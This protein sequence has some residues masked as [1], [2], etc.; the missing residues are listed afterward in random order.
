MDQWNT[1]IKNTIELFGFNHKPEFRLKSFNETYNSYKKFT[2]N[3][4]YAQLTL[5]LIV[6]IFFESILS[7]D[8]LVIFKD[9]RYLP[10]III[11]H[12]I[13]KEYV[14]YITSDSLYYLQNIFILTVSIYCQLNILD[15]QIQLPWQLIMIRNIEYV[16]FKIIYILLCYWEKN[17]LLQI[18]WIF[19][20]S[21][22]VIYQEIAQYVS[23]T[24]D[25]WKIQKDQN[26]QRFIVESILNMQDNEQKIEFYNKLK[27][28]K[29]KKYGFTQLLEYIV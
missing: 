10:I 25:Y 18:L 7:N 19:M 24:D 6:F 28:Q 17:K 29:D 27:K 20:L 5:W 1:L 3:Q 11:F 9:R 2:Q 26:Q 23:Y 8:Y 12:I 14:Q 13:S 15:A 22:L 4:K 21:G 16:P